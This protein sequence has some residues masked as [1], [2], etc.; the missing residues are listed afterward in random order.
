M[1]LGTIPPPPHA[2]IFKSRIVCG[3]GF[4]SSPWGVWLGENHPSPTRG[5]WDHTGKLLLAY[6]RLEYPSESA[7]PLLVHSWP[8]RGETASSEVTL[9]SWSLSVGMVQETVARFGL[10][11]PPSASRIHFLSCHY[12]SSLWGKIRILRNWLNIGTYFELFLC[13]GCSSW[14][15]H[16]ILLNV[17]CC[18]RFT[19][20]ETEA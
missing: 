18:L 9:C 2:P 5:D 3:E 14:E 15:P 4:S 12:F 16:P 8:L 11:P 17:R 13:T 10:E 7:F 1:T 19:Q 6:P 20:E